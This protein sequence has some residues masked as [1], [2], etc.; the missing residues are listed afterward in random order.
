MAARLLQMSF[1]PLQ[2]IRRAPDFYR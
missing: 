2:A 1:A